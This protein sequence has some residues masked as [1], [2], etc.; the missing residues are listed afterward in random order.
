MK[1]FRELSLPFPLRD[2][3]IPELQAQKKFYT[4][5]VND[6]I[7]QYLNPKLMASF[8]I[9]I[10]SLVYF[11]SSKTTEFATMFHT[12]VVNTSQGWRVDSC[13]INWDLTP[14]ITQ[15]E[16][17]RNQSAPEFYP[18]SSPVINELNAIHY[19]HRENKDPRDCELLETYT[20]KFQTAY[21]VNPGLPHRVTYQSQGIRHC[22][23]IRFHL[24]DIPNWETALAKFSDRL[25]PS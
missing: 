2:S 19:Y 17:Y 18:N 7:Q 22:V 1:H 9:P 12:D 24:S 25:L 20:P 10:R 8:D 23:S 6:N 14:S 5:V 11:G 16:V 15:F 3:A 21:L 4:L 13:A